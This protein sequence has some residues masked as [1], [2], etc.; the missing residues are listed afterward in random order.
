M[1]SN[2]ADIKKRL[3]Q[4]EVMPFEDIV[5]IDVARGVELIVSKSAGTTRKENLIIMF[6]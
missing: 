5:D 2:C 3:L 6:D 1:S 4:R